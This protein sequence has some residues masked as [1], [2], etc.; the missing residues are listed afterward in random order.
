MRPQ[1]TTKGDRWKYKATT[2]THNANSP[3]GEDNAY[4]LLQRPHHHA[5][6]VTE[7]ASRRSKE[8]DATRINTPNNHRSS[9]R[10]WESFLPE[11]FLSSHSQ[12]A[13]SSPRVDTT[14]STYFRLKAMGLDPRGKTLTLIPTC[15]T[16][17]RKRPRDR[18]SDASTTP[19]K[20]LHA[21]GSSHLV[22]QPQPDTGYVPF[23]QTT[24]APVPNDEDEELF[25]AV[26]AARNAMSDSI[27]FFQDE[28]KQD[29]LRRSQISTGTRTLASNTTSA[30]TS[31][32]VVNGG[33]SSTMSLHKEPP[34]A[35]RNRISKFLPREMYADV[36]MRRR[37]DA[38]ASTGG[39]NAVQSPS[40]RRR[41][42]RPPV[43][44]GPGGTDCVHEH[45]TRKAH[46]RDGKSEVVSGIEI[47]VRSRNSEIRQSAAYSSERQED[48][49][50]T[51]LVEETET[52]AHDD[53][54][55]E[56]EDGDKDED[57]DEEG[58]DFG[59]AAQRPDY[60]IS[61]ATDE[62]EE[63]GNEEMDLPYGNGE[64]YITNG[65]A[66]EEDALEEED[67]EDDR[68]EESDVDLDGD[69][70]GDGYG[71][72]ADDMDEEGDEDEE[73]DGHGERDEDEERDKDEGEK[74]SPTKWTGKGGTSVEDAIEL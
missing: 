31:D 40:T 73:R 62:E 71:Y 70:D 43:V 17:D 3:P 7:N 36:M 63:E 41:W 51:D 61:N 5:R 18:D 32:A 45:G 4:R 48:D 13:A 56:D 8:A 46:L 22:H 26:R 16:S 59:E 33:D 21:L 68:R 9:S 30:S 35:Y 64:N 74:T 1:S 38:G 29:E 57:R 10:L 65:E 42:R 67:I 23:T 50:E 12:L 20:R 6:S 53:A 2:M 47:E 34:P 72:G 52:Q 28:I 25:T 66:S 69:G 49:V 15:F 11:G 24:R 39:K 55:D 44:D 27:S 54:E 60:F 14:R 19:G 37:R 58:Q